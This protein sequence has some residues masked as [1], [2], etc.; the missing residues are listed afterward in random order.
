MRKKNATIYDVAEA[1][2]VSIATVSRVIN[3]GSNVRPEMRERVNAA[4]RQ[5]EFRPQVVTKSGDPNRVWAVGL[6]YPLYEHSDIYNATPEEDENVLFMDSVIRGASTQAS[7]LGYSLFSSA[8][9]FNH[10]GGSHPLQKLSRAVDAVIITDR[11]SLDVGAMRFAK[12]MQAVHLS[13]APG[14]NF[15]SIVR[16]DNELGMAQIV[17]HLVNVHGVR[18]FGFVS[19]VA[20]SP[21]SE[22]RQRAFLAEIEKHGGVVRP[23]NVLSGEFSMSCAADE[24]EKYLYADHVMP[25]AWVSAN[26][27][28]AL[29]LMKTLARHNIQVPGDVLVTG[30]DDVPMARKSTPGLTTVHQSF[31][32]LGA[33]AVEAAVG[34]LDG[35]I[36][37]GSTVM[38][39]T[40]LVVRGSCGC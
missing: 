3:G 8:I 23:G 12:R 25:Q 19:G 6:A 17:E 18:D 4:I 40:E 15:G 28:M 5:L 35:T 27:Q 29:G 30:F 36:E 10:S 38:L 9:P 11:L 16:V 1:A 34:L 31:L 20:N 33:T 14:E 39:P 24:L 32:E 22:T 21:D 7:L 26:D 13:G 37:K 2:Y